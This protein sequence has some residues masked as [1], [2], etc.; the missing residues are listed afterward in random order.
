MFQG[1]TSTLF[2]LALLVVGGGQADDAPKQETSAGVVRIFNAVESPAPLAGKVGAASLQESDS[3]VARVLRLA[4]QAKVKEHYHPYFNEAL[5]VHA[6]TITMML[7][8]ETHELVAGDVVYMPAG[9]I[10]S[11]KNTTETEA[12]I[13]VVWATTGE[14]GP[15]FVYGRPES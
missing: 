3:M 2:T 10:I 9:T 8:D 12:V 14:D 13:F 4:P 1:I 15:L 6:G 11:G 5:F 7:N